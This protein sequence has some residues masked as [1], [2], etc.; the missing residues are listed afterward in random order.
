MLQERGVTH[1][2]REQQP[3]D[4]VT[5]QNTQSDTLA[6]KPEKSLCNKE[7]PQAC[8]DSSG[9]GHWEIGVKTCQTL[10]LVIF[11]Q[12]SMVCCLFWPAMCAYLLVKLSTIFHSIRDRSKQL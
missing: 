12:K 9:Q 6:V 5:R 3:P 11:W 7:S 4:S 8:Q 2:L 1:A 10:Y